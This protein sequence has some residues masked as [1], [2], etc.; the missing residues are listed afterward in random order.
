MERA[1]LALFTFEE[2][3]WL[4]SG[5]H[6]VRICLLISRIFVVLPL[7]RDLK[8]SKSEAWLRYPSFAFAPGMETITVSRF[9]VL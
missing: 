9:H 2:G 4:T 3:D 7:Q 8:E 5:I 1:L 6:I